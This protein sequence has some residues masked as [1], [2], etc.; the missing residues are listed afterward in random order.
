MPFAFRVYKN[1]LC[2]IALTHKD[3]QGE[4]T[5]VCGSKAA[6]MQASLLYIYLHGQ[7]AAIGTGS[8][9][10]GLS[11]MALRKGWDINDESSSAVGGVDCVLISCMQR[12][13]N[14]PVPVQQPTPQLH[15]IK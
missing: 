13:F 4:R 12:L 7:Q 8:A 6:D 15:I 3:K 14:K 2:F 11:A 10:K 5:I 1:M 9:Y